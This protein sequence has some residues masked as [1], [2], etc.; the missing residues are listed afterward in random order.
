MIQEIQGLKVPVKMTIL[1][2]GLTVITIE[3]GS[4]LV[5]A[6]FAFRVGAIHD[7]EGFE[8]TAH[9]L[10][11]MLFEGPARDDVHPK[12]KTLAWRAVVGY[13]W[14]NPFCTWYGLTGLTEDF[15][16]M[17][18]ALYSICFEPIFGTENIEAERP[19]IEQEMRQAYI[20]RNNEFNFWCNSELYPNTPVLSRSGCGTKESIKKINEKNLLDFFNAYYSFKNAVL[21]VSGGLSH[22]QVLE[23][24]VLLEPIEK[25]AVLVLPQELIHFEA[26]LNLSFGD[27]NGNSKIKFY[28]PHPQNLRDDVYLGKARAL[29]SDFPFG[30]LMQRLRGKHSLV[31]S[32]DGGSDGFPCFITCFSM[33]T[34]ANHFDVVQEILLEEI[35]RV[36]N[37]L[38]DDKYF[39]YLR[40]YSKMAQIESNEKKRSNGKFINILRERWLEADYE[41]E[42]EKYVTRMTRED[43]VRVAR[44]YL[45]PAKMS[46]IRVV[47]FKK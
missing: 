9:F 43:L 5:T 44:E 13:A 47:P 38:Y 36:Q 33:P 41:F 4:E 27:K 21:I 23:Q 42:K 35:E 26:G 45:D 40:I 20:D 34:D 30:F 24:V 39:Q 11:H 46:I 14:T 8:G 19:V 7:P 16:E 3:T 6:E 10:E 17:L 37:D 28:F 15:N 2:N 29:L 31:Y 25:N 1:G 12:L 22:D 18:H 32:I